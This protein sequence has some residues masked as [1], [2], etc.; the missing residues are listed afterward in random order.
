MKK[1]TDGEYKT[2]LSQKNPWVEPLGEYINSNTKMLFRCKMCGKEWEAKPAQVMNGTKCRPCAIKKYADAQRKSNTE[3]L[4]SLAIKDPS[5][6][7]L[8]QYAG[9]NTKIL[10]R[11]I[12]CDYTWCATPG[13]LLSGKGCRKCAN[14][15]NAEKR[16]KD[17][18]EFID[19][20][21]TKNPF[22]EAL[23]EYKGASQR[24]D[25]MC[26]TCGYI[27][28]SK[29]HHI[30][31]GHGC[32]VCGGSQKKGQ[33]QFISELKSVNP[34]VEIIGQ[35]SNAR[36]K[37]LCRCRFCNNEWDAAPDKLLQGTGCPE[38]DKRNKT[39][40]PEQAIYYYIKQ[41][42]P[43]S[44]NRFRG[45]NKYVEL[46]VYI[47]SL[48]IGIEYDGVYYHRDTQRDIKKYNDCQANGITLI[49]IIESPALIN[50]DTADKIIRRNKPYSYE[51]L[52]ECIEELLQEFGRCRDI[53]TFSD[54]ISIREQY[55]S[56]L[57]RNSLQSKYPSIAAEWLF[58]KNGGITPEMVS[59]ASNDKY[60]WKCMTCQ[61]EWSAAISDRTSGGKGC[62]KCGHVSTSIKLT[63]S[64]EKFV[65]ELKKINPAIR[66]L[67]PYQRT[68]TNI[69]FHCDRCGNTCRSHHQHKAF[70]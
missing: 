40:F 2:R 36:T 58:S 15:N 24:I 31:A 48:R 33:T 8:E 22:V 55:Y 21:K 29:P 3:F 9:S 30:L 12:K 44:I 11:C 14:A 4:E 64:H 50:E 47:P 45:E 27:W 46:D 52:N 60:W 51:T 32:P 26:K 56:I 23:E 41:L 28:K 38:C 42:Y 34:Y 35:Y 1:L 69:L 25:F 49:R 66:P 18:Q 43:D 10:V 67:E 5:I 68:H 54:S 59:Y 16:R 13:N 65:E 19:E 62:P 17:P 53:D 37:V 20:L 61:N 63:K 57:K 7:P 39:S 70:V 6:V